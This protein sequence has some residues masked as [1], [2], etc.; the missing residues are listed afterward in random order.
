MSHFTREQCYKVTCNPL[1]LGAR[2]LRPRVSDHLRL[3]IFAKRA[4]NFSEHLKYNRHIQLDR[5]SKLIKFKK[6][7]QLKNLTQ[8]NAFSRSKKLLVLARDRAY[9]T[10][11]YD[12]SNVN[13]KLSRS[14]LNDSGVDVSFNDSYACSDVTVKNYDCDEG[15]EMSNPSVFNSNPL[16]SDFCRRV[17]LSTDIFGKY[18]V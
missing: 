9:N 17:K 4:L 16:S 10:T 6:Q 7:S 11:T 1:D 5:P 3:K 15:V 14:I 2:S 18:Q 12:D 8:K 13:V